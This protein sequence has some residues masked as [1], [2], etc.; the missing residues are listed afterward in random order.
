M[1]AE[2]NRPELLDWEPIGRGAVGAVYRARDAASG[3]EVA[4]KVL[5]VGRGDLQA[6]GR[7]RQEAAAMESVQHPGVVRVHC[8][9][10]LDDE[11]ALVMEFV[12]GVSLKNL[13]GSLHERDSMAILG[14]LGGALDA[15][16]RVGVIHRDLKPANILI[17]VTG[18]CRVADF[19]IAKFVGESIHAPGRNMVRTRTGIVVGTPTYLSPEIVAGDPVDRQGDVYS[20]GVVAYELLVGRPPFLGGVYQ[21]LKAHTS[22]PA[23]RPDSVKPDFPIDVASVL[24][25]ALAKS[26]SERPSSAGELVADLI[27]ASPSDWRGGGPSDLVPLVQRASRSRS[28]SR[29]R[30]TGEPGGENVEVDTLPEPSSPPRTSPLLPKATPAQ[31]SLPRTR[32][33][34]RPVA[35]AAV[36]VFGAAI[37]AFMI[38]A[39]LH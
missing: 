29:R 18:R 20:L 9:Y 14:Q 8:I 5:Q 28:L 16:H 2:G 24:S 35:V 3:S 31:V 17:D 22:E 33:R 26:P 36:A 23:P 19:G 39:L 7:F 15:I 37:G 30:G 38:L 27:E 13:T 1:T 21:L 11:I 34:W 4:I 10:E 6:L 12:D 25:A 32:L